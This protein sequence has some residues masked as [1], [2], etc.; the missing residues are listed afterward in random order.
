MAGS[1]VGVAAAPTDETV[2]PLVLT[3]HYVWVGAL[4][5]EAPIRVDGRVKP[6]QHEPGNPG[7]GKIS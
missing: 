1:H 4:L 5:G 6:V 2:P 3:Q 7:A